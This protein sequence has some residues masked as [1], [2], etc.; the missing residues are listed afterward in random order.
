MERFQNFMVALNI[1]D[2]KRKKALL[3]HY[4]GDE[5][6]NLFDTLPDVADAD[7]HYIAATNALNTYFKPKKNREY[8]VHIFRQSKQ[9]A[10]ESV[11]ELHARLRHLAQTCEFTDNDREIKKQI[12]AG[13]SSNKPRRKALSDDKMKFT[14]LLQAARTLSRTRSQ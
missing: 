8:E 12:I 3:L 2:H 10:G 1:T 13:C 6:H 4:A 14:D 5:V 11:D 9:R 7:D